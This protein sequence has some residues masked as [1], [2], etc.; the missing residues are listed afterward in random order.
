MSTNLTISVQF[1]GKFDFAEGDWGFHPVRAEVRWV[2][3]DV[4]AARRVRLG[5]ATR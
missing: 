1:V 2:W 3:M 4:D 5:F